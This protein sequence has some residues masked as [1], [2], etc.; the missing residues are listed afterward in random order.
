MAEIQ[1]RQEQAKLIVQQY[2]E[3][4]GTNYNI[5][6]YNNEFN[7]NAYTK[8]KE[9]ISKVGKGIWNGAK[10]IGKALFG[11][12]ARANNYLQPIDLEAT[13]KLEN[14]DINKM[15]EPHISGK[16]NKKNKTI[17]TLA[18]V[19][20]GVLGGPIGAVLGNAL[21]SKAIEKSERAK[22]RSEFIKNLPSM[23]IQLCHNISMIANKVNGNITNTGVAGK[24]IKS[25]TSIEGFMSNSI[26]T[27]VDAVSQGIESIAEFKTKFDKENQEVNQLINSGKLGPIDKG[28]WNINLIESG[29]PLID[30]MLKMNEYMSRLIRAPF[31]MVAQTMGNAGAVLAADSDSNSNNSE[32]SEEKD[33]SPKKGKSLISKIGGFFKGLFG[34]GKDDNSGKGSSDHIYQR[35]YSGS[36]QTA[37]DTERQT[38]A[39]SGCGP[40]AAAT[41]MNRYGLHGDLNKAAKFATTRG[42]KEVNGG[43]Y[44]EYFNDYLSQKGIQTKPTQSNAEVVRSLAQGKPVIMMGRN[45]NNNSNTPYGS[46]YSHYVV[47]TGLDKNGQVI[48]EDSEDRRG[49]TRYSLADTLKNTS[50]KITTSAN[51]KYGR[52]SSFASVFS[53]YTESMIKG[54]YGGYYNALF[55][56]DTDNQNGTTPSNQKQGSSDITNVQDSSDVETRK[57]I[58]WDFLT[59]HGC[60]KNLTAAIMGNMKRESGFN[61]T[62]GEIASGDG[63]AKSILNMTH[64]QFGDPYG[65]GWGLCQWSYAPG[66]AALYNWC[67]AHNLS[68]DTLEGQLNYLMAGLKGI[69]VDSAVNS[70]N[71]S[72]FGHDGSGT[73]SYVYNCISAAGGLDYL[74]KLS[75]EDA[76]AEFYDLYERGANREGDLAKSIP[77]AQEIYNQFANSSG[78]GKGKKINA[79]EFFSNKISKYGRSK[80][81]TNS[82]YP[83]LRNNKLGRGKN[84]DK[85][86]YIIDDSN[87]AVMYNGETIYQTTK[88]G[89]I[90]YFTHSGKEITDEGFVQNVHSGLTNYS[91]Y[92]S[93]KIPT[94]EVL[95]D[96]SGV[97]Y[98]YNGETV[99]II[100]N[101]DKGTTEI[102]TYSDKEI[103]PNS[104]EGKKIFEGYQSGTYTTNTV[105]DNSKLKTKSNIVYDDSSF[106]KDN[107]G[108]YIKTSNGKKVT[109]SVNGDTYMD[110]DGNLITNQETIKEIEGKIYSMGDIKTTSAGL[111]NQNAENTDTENNT[112][113]PTSTSSG[114]FLTKFGEYIGALTK[115][116]YGDYYTAL[117]GD[118]E[119][120]GG[121]DNQDIPSSSKGQSSL[122]YTAA[123]VFNAV[124][125]VP[126]DQTLSTLVTVNGVQVS[127]RHDCSGFM[128]SIIKA[129]GYDCSS[130]IDETSESILFPPVP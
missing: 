102:K 32:S 116:L 124:G 45:S 1:Q 6:D 39:D 64:P 29:N 62:A 37:G 122:I 14:Y 88:D 80:N 48:V 77:W 130:D 11:S 36:F 74:N 13:N 50:I 5:N 81:I 16:T 87:K 129:M 10:K 76:V 57:K 123:L 40:A 30:S 21:S 104:K 73:L 47:A 108:N 107:E 69:D 98:T 120:N 43:T 110:E 35:D 33:T 84:D 91:G 49:Q 2:N 94:K 89:Q 83:R 46:K 96:S 90:K 23:F 114:S 100:T 93:E 115:G 51:G 109:Y 86:Y 85:E 18:T 127:V 72:K 22:E 66:H 56:L 113:S 117:F 112:T 25:D 95:V 78:S 60:S 19:A 103:D 61:P 15:E 75:I 9:G 65:C 41:V 82:K 111:T 55:G 54:M 97:P 8:V 106:F 28:F 20:G 126:Y 4:N 26:N 105:T 125:K 67:E 119:T 34:K 118:D 27:S 128:S 99:K 79:S 92:Y 101:K 12:N 17:K 38:I 59:S 70:N 71:E 52:G 3:E 24:D 44:P 63:N 7:G 68:A 31:S 121:T 42:Y 53:N 58:I